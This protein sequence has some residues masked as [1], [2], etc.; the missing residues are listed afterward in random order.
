MATIFI[1]PG[2]AR[3][4]G[5]A[6]DRPTSFANAIR[7]A[8]PG[9][10]LRLLPGTYRHP[11]VVAD[12]EASAEAPIVI[13]GGGGV[14]L[15]S[16]WEPNDPPDDPAEADHAQVKIV[17]SRGITVCDLA[18]RNAWPTAVYIGDSQQVR[19]ARL[20]IVGGTYAV[21]AQGEATRDLLVEDNRWVQDET[22]RLI[23]SELT[24]DQIHE[25]RSHQEF[26]GDFFRAQSIRGFVTIR[27]NHVRHAFNG[28]HFFADKAE[29]APGRFSINVEICHNRFEYIRDN[30]VEP[31]TT[32]V[33]WWVHHNSFHN[34]YKLFS[35]ER[36]AGGHWY[37]FANTAWFDERP[38]PEHDCNRGGAVLK[39]KEVKPA[40]EAAELPRWPVW[41]FHNSLFL[42]SSYCKKGAIR[43]FTHANNAVQYC[44]GTGGTAA[45]CRPGQAVFGPVP[46]TPGCPADPEGTRFTTEWERLDIRFFGDVWSHPDFPA[47][48]QAQGYPVA[49]LGD[50][51]G[52]TDPSHGD[53]RLR[54]GAAAAGRGAELMVPMPDGTV[55]HSPAGLDAGA[56]QGGGSFGGPAY[57]PWRDTAPLGLPAVAVA[58]PAPAD[59]R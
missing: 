21:F 7:R 57:R 31:E 5:A 11:L 25:H 23:W 34:V 44:D 40:K 29:A 6:A 51:P 30:A 46:A 20:D 50:P 43:H 16:G 58:A 13:R 28:V 39:L 52:F 15:D 18:I 55:W 36:V 59:G 3:G 48:L 33:N 9:D 41:M 27:R 56:A 1:A 14:V 24:F 26:D 47:G 32:A 2:S 38:G 42:R 12:K 54:P 49:G 53:F 4:D 45:I 35:L 22:E 17:R 37:I 10:V 19:L 8:Q